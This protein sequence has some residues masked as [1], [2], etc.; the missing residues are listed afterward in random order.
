MKWAIWSHWFKEMERESSDPSTNAQ[1]RFKLFKLFSSEMETNYLSH[2]R[3]RN[4]PPD[5]IFGLE[6]EIWRYASS[7]MTSS[8]MTNPPNPIRKMFLDL[9]TRYP[10]PY[11][12]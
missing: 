9:V 2:L 4:V 10:L 8:P 3:Y 5:D 7:L 6:K 1:K 12:F 11:P